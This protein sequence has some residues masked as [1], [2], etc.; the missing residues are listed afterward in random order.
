LAEVQAKQTVNQNQFQVDLAASRANNEELRKTN[1]ELRTDLQRKGDRMV[2]EQSPPIPVRARP[3]P[4]SQAI[5]NAVIPTNFM[6]PKITF[7]GTEDPEAHITTFHTQMMISGG[8]D[9]MHYKLFMGTFSGTTLDWFISLLDGHI[10]SFDQFSTLFREQFIINQAPPPISF[11]LFDVKQ[12]QEEPLKDFLNQFEALVV[13]LHTKDEAMVVHA[14][15]RGILSRPFSD[16]LI[17]CRPKTFK[18]I[19]HPA[20][21]HINVEEVTEKTWKRWSGKTLGN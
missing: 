7:T 14:F 20:L 4:F 8:I 3:M 11:D 17:R 19:C 13:K 18:E 2:D 5:I 6:I 16:S 10:T 21:T 1:E 15:R 9:T 12:C